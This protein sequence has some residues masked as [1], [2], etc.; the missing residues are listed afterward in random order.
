MSDLFWRRHTRCARFTSLRDISLH[1][2]RP[3]ALRAASMLSM[4]VMP[5]LRA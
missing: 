4:A 1:R 5:G 2:N 3:P